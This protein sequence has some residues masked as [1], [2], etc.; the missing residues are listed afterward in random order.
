[1]KSSVP[2]E[3]KQSEDPSTLSRMKSEDKIAIP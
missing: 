1:M 2:L 3:R